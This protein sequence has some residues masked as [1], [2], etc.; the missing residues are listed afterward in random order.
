MFA[1]MD[2]SVLAKKIYT[3]TARMTYFYSAVYKLQE[4]GI[5]LCHLRRFGSYSCDQEKQ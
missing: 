2:I 1:N 3:K 5:L 4:Y